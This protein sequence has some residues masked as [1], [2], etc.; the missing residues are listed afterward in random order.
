MQGLAEVVPFF[1]CFYFMFY[2]VHFLC[3]CGFSQT[4]R[5]EVS[6]G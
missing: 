5:G 2:F 6:G 3:R 4:I 1:L